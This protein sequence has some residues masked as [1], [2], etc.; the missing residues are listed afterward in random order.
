MK[1]EK[2][3]ILTHCP[4]CAKMGWNIEL[5]SHCWSPFDRGVVECAECGLIIDFQDENWRDKL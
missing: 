3:N 1:N 5:M 2:I 4:R